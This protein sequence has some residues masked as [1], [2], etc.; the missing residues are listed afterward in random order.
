[1][2]RSAPTDSGTTVVQDGAGVKD[3]REPLHYVP[4]IGGMTDRLEVRRDVDGKDLAVAR[5]TDLVHS[6]YS[7]VVRP[8]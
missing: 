8:V 2:T 3:A 5:G 7:P 4:A 1:M 6:G